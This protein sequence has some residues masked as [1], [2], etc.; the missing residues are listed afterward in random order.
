MNQVNLKGTVGHDP[1]L[2]KVKDTEV[3][4]ISIHCAKNMLD[5]DEQWTEKD[6]FWVRVACWGNLAKRVAATIKKGNVVVVV[7]E[8]KPPTAWIGKED[9]EAHAEVQVRARDVA[10][11]VPNPKNKGEKQEP[12]DEEV[13]PSDE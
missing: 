13:E 10:I 6:P 12:D 1:E 7:G 5:K 3:C 9:Q 11:V 2:K 8:L 4:N